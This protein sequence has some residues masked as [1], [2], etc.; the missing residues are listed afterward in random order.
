MHSRILIS[1]HIYRWLTNWDSR[2]TENKQKRIR[3][4][5]SKKYKHYF[6]NFKGLPLAIFLTRC[7]YYDGEQLKARPKSRRPLGWHT[8]RWKGNTKMDL[9]DVVLEGMDFIH[10]LHY[11]DRW[12]A[13]ENVVRTFGLHKRWGVS[14]VTASTVCCLYKKESVQRT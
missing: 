3:C 11:R 5:Y 10:L 9:R 1:I 12:R 2:T 14:W 4:I 7:L 6:E 13:L 8:R